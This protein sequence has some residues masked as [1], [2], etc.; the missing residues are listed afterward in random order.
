MNKTLRISLSIVFILLYVLITLI[1]TNSMTVS[2]LNISVEGGYTTALEDLSTDE[3]FNTED[4]PV[5]E[6]DYSLQVIQIAE[7]SDKELF[8]YVYQPCADYGN[9][10]A[11]SI[12]ISC[13]LHNE[14]KIKN[15]KLTLLNKQGVFYKYVVNGLQVKDETTRYYEIISIFRPWDDN[16]DESLDNGNTIDE[17]VYKVAKQYTLIDT[18]NGTVI[19]VAETEVVEVIDKYVGL[20]RYKETT[21]PSWINGDSVDS[22]F[23]AFSTDKDIDRLYEADVYYTSQYVHRYNYNVYNGDMRDVSYGNVSEK[24]SYLNYTQS[25]TVEGDKDLNDGLIWNENVYSFERIQ[26]VDDFIVGEN[27]SNIFNNPVFNTTVQ[28]KITDEGLQDLQSMKWILRFTETDYEYDNQLDEV[29]ITP[30]EFGGYENY[31]IV[32]DVTILRLKFETDGV[33]YN[34][35]VIDNKQTGDGIPDNETMINMEPSDMFKI[36]LLLFLIVILVSILGPFLP[37]IISFVLW[38]IKTV[39]K[40]AWW[41]ISLPFNVFKKRE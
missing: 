30:G 2:A 37:T 39:F 14:L 28:T 10:V 36:I 38:V 31:T 17:V 4:Y 7:S 12:N 29:V 6:D 22:H 18:D 15:Y 33:V 5:I 24:Y 20:V 3:N 19:S 8:V 21:A 13:A 9:L 11:S 23:V 16:K 1:P 26:S 41:I 40:V 27:R 32:G 35:G 25:K 34:C